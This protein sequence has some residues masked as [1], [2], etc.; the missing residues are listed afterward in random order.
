MQNFK[1]AK[2]LRLCLRQTIIQLLQV[3]WKLWLFIVILAL[4]NAL[5]IKYLTNFTDHDGTDIFF[6]LA[7]L[8]NFLFISLY[9]FLMW[10]VKRYGKY[11]YTIMESSEADPSVL[12]Q[13]RFPGVFGLIQ[14]SVLMQSFYLT[15]FTLVFAYRI[16][17]STYFEALSPVIIMCFLIPIVLPTYTLLTHVEAFTHQ[18]NIEEILKFMYEQE[19]AGHTKHRERRTSTEIALGPPPPGYTAANHPIHKRKGHGPHIHDEEME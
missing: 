12:F 13:F 4:L 15:F 11:V 8:M 2:Y 9:L 18:E 1:F 14:F 6:A 17:A 7:Y 19:R 3:N 16:P 10:N 5:R